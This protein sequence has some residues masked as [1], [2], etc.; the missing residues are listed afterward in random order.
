[1]FEFANDK[2][3]LCGGKGFGLQAG[4]SR[5]RGETHGENDEFQSFKHHFYEQ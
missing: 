3:C 5:D 4:L 2:R 1:M